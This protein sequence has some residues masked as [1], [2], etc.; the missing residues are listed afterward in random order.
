MFRTK[1]LTKIA[2]AA[3][4]MMSFGG[5]GKSNPETIEDYGSSSG[6]TVAAVEE[7]T[8]EMVEGTS[9]EIDQ[10]MIDNAG[11][12]KDDFE[13][14][15][16]KVY[17]SISDFGISM[18]TLPSIRAE[19]VTLDNLDAEGYAK[20]LFGDSAN[21]LTER[22]RPTD[23]YRTWVDNEPGN[24][25][26][27]SEEEYWEEK[28][29]R[30]DIWYAYEGKYQDNDYY[31]L[32]TYE[33]ETGT[34]GLQMFPKNAG[35]VIGESNLAYVNKYDPAMFKTPS[36][37]EGGIYYFQ[38]VGYI[39]ENGEMVL[40]GVDFGEAE[41]IATK[42][43]DSPNR[44]TMSDAQLENRTRDFFEGTLGINISEYPI[45]YQNNSGII[46][47]DYFN[48]DNGWPED[49]TEAEKI[50]LVF[51]PENNFPFINVDS[52]VRDGY[53]V[54]ISADLGGF[55]DPRNLDSSAEMGYLNIAEEGIV[56][57]SYK[58]KYNI[59]ERLSESTTLLEFNTLME[60]MKEALQNSQ[61]FNDLSTNKMNFENDMVLSFAAVESPDDPHEVTF[62]PAVTISG[63][64]NMRT[65]YS[66]TLNAIDGTVISEGEE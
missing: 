20:K 9:V 57:F 31:L 55:V 13:V 27:F 14:G 38:N 24:D 19:K 43:M 26:H 66:I 3:A 16:K 4:M 37:A 5:C 46:R 64:D 11:E 35:D 15:S 28:E 32:V 52:S 17:R 40:K 25:L 42:M 51:S 18:V 47:M 61:T 21:Q 22:P 6:G 60:C 2:L 7:G 39:Q 41:D 65:S 56:G 59:K 49:E 62:V 8:D 30:E 58:W 44:C 50:E 12:C 53:S 10:D 63:W 34:A 23:N 36:I 48:Y 1:K 33:S 29:S 54:G 45:R